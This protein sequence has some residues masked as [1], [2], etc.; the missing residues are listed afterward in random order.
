MN[1]MTQSQ[2]QVFQ[3]YKEIDEKSPARR[4]PAK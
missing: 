2:R 3:L 1:G 4:P